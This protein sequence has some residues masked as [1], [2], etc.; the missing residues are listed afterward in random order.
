MDMMLLYVAAWVPY[1]VR[2]GRS[3][4]NAGQQ[5]AIAIS[6]RIA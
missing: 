3:A 5:A 6:R 1:F 4:L 2:L